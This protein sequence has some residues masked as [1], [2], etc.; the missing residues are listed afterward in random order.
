MYDT[1]RDA[2][3]CA[4][5]KRIMIFLCSECK[6]IFNDCIKSDC[7]RKDH[8]N[9]EAFL[10]E[11]RVR[12]IVTEVIE[13]L[14][15]K[16]MTGQISEL[17]EQMADVNTRVNSV[18]R[19]MIKTGLPR[20]TVNTA[21][22]LGRSEKKAGKIH[23]FPKPD[24]PSPAGDEHD[25][26]LRLRSGT[27]AVSKCGSSAGKIIQVGMV[28]DA[29][30]NRTSGSNK[31]HAGDSDLVNDVGGQI[32]LSQV[33]GGV[34]AALD[35]LEGG[36][37]AECDR[38]GAEFQRVESRRSKQRRRM[39]AEAQCGTAT[40]ASGFV[41]EPKRMW[42]YVGRAGNQTDVNMVGEYIASKLGVGGDQLVVEE[43]KTEGMTKSYKV[44]VNHQYYDQ[45]NKSDFWPEGILFRRFRFGGSRP[46]G[47][48]F[49]MVR[50][51]SARK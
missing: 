18:L 35:V 50:R 1:H 4:Q 9:N 51:T 41:G 6:L 27:G 24:R 10:T 14:I 49:P 5:E 2:K 31:S 47:S 33:S 43:L 20:E 16:I 44:G 46:V 7:G 48:G 23:G 32:T 19:N 17:I 29:W 3:C 22:E 12:D 30:K 13:T 28:G 25:S 11:D 15:P 26:D 39:A 42:L 37:Q 45:V 34:E 38:D 21:S 36:I 40:D 8:G